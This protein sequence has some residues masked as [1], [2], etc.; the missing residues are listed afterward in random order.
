MRNRVLPGTFTPLLAAAV[1][2]ALAAPAARSQAVDVAPDTTH[3]VIRGFGGHN[4]A[5][6]IADLTPA[7]VDTAFGTGDGQLGLSI[8][9]MRI[10]PN[11]AAWQRQ[12]A[13]ARLAKAKG[14]T[15]FATP[16]TPPAHMKTNNSLISGRLLPEYYADYAT[17]LLGFASLMRDNGAELHGI[18]IQN[19]PNWDATYEGCLWNATEFIHFLTAQGARFDTVKVM[20]PETLNFSKAFSD[21]ILND[22]AAAEHLDIVAGHLYGA[23][24]SD[25]PLARA[26]GKELWMTEHYTDSSSDANDWAKAMPVGLELHNSMKSN[27]NAYVWWYI[28]RSYGLMTENG[29]VSKRGYIMSQYARHV[30]PGLVRIGATEKPYPDVYLTAYKDDAGKIVLVAV[31]TG[32]EERQLDVDFNTTTAT[33]LARYTTSADANNIEDGQYEVVNGKAMAFIAPSSVATFVKHAADVNVTRSLRIVRSGL[34]PNRF[35]GLFTG[36]VSLTNTSGLPLK[37]KMRLVLDDL[38]PGVS[39]ENGEQGASST[40]FIT[41]PDSDLEPGETVIVATRFANPDRVNIRYTPT[42]HNATY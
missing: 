7:Q 22:A 42:V 17:H 12:V 26:K 21:P 6:W 31:N 13:T 39:L 4:G 16:W 5:G 8:M 30:R 40:P 19:E 41:L 25:Y 33:T 11:P 38:P 32:T 2:M 27:Y 10:D 24:P 34:V 3:Q 23:S 14:V 18:S 37:G 1:L 15:L 29:L 36:A 35:T 20:A 9:R 28:R